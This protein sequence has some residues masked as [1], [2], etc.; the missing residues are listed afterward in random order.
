MSGIGRVSACCP[1]AEPWRVA[2]LLLRTRE[3]KRNGL[4]LLPAQTR[5]SRAVP[6]RPGARLVFQMSKN[7][8]GQPLPPADRSI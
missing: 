6:N 4:S 8:P 5:E 1:C 3:L 7:Y 2:S